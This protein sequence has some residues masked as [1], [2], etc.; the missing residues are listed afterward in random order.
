MGAADRGV[1]VAQESVDVPPMPSYAHGEII[2]AQ[3]ALLYSFPL[4]ELF[5]R[6]FNP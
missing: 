4:R 1:M 5:E 3:G 6:E 2:I